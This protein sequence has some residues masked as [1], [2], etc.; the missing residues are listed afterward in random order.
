[1]IALH[2]YRRLLNTRGYDWQLEQSEEW[3]YN[4]QLTDTSLK[5]NHFVKI[6]KF[7]ST[8]KW[9]RA[10]LS[11]VPATRTILGHCQSL[12]MI[13]FWDALKSKERVFQF[14]REGPHYIRR[15]LSARRKWT[16]LET[17]S[18]HFS[19]PRYTPLIQCTIVKDIWTAE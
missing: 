15:Y 3:R 8:S 9:R 13:P 4:V 11:V 12:N 6:T 5:Q 1:L 19:P 7:Y 2:P 14:Q 18:I 10:S 17:L 16:R